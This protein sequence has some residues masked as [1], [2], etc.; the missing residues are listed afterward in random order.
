MIG[1]RKTPR[2][3]CHHSGLSKLARITKGYSKTDG[4]LSLSIVLTWLGLGCI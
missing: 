3:R 4:M 1:N 2:V